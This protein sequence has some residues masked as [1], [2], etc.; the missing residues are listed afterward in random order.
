MT[1]VLRLLI[2][3][4]GIFNFHFLVLDLSWSAQLLH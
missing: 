4:Q 1:L 2:L 3:F